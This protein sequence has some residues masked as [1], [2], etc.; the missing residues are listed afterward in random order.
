MISKK[1]LNGI[2][3]VVGTKYKV[4]P[5]LIKAMCQCESS[6]EPRAYRYEPAFWTN[7]L[8]NNPEWKDKDP[9]VV[10]SSYGLMQLMWTTA[11]GLGF[12][13]TQEQL[14]DP[15][16]NVEL[17]TRLVRMLIDEVYEKVV[18]RDYPWLS[19]LD[20]ALARYNGGKS[21]NPI[22]PAVLPLGRLVSVRNMKYVKRVLTTW[23]ELYNAGE[24][25]CVQ[26]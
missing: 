23:E 3:C 19:P 8:K 1:I 5:L 13:G 26:V 14:W 9:A 24:E 21:K 12:R 7:Y 18:L 2:V 10:S 20:I 17:G 11:W 4:P 25:P 22:Y 16:T 15:A 6:Y